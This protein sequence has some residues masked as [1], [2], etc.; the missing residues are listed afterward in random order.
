MA[1]E[2]GLVVV[3]DPDATQR[4]EIKNWVD[5]NSAVAK[6]KRGLAEPSAV[7]QAW[8]NAQGKSIQDAVLD[9]IAK[10]VRHLVKD[11]SY[12]SPGV[13][14]ARATADT[15]NSALAAAISTAGDFAEIS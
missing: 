15:S 11:P 9:E 6:L 13:A 14:A 1:S 5:T 12:E 2:V 7:L 4:T 8:A 3:V 10:L